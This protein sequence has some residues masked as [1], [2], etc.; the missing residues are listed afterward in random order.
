MSWKTTLV[1]IVLFVAAGVAIL[2]YS[3]QIERKAEGLRLPGVVEIQEVRLG[4]KVGG[5]VADVLV[6][7]G[8]MAK[9]N[10]LLVRFEAPELE[11]QR[12][13][14]QGRVASMQ[15][16]FEKAKN[17][18]RAE[19]IRQAR[20]DLET[21][22]ADLKLG[23]EDFE[24]AE[25]LIQQKTISRADYDIA[26][27]ALHRSR[28]RVASARAHLDLLL[29]GTRPEDIALAAANLAE[30]RGRL[31][32]IEANLAETRVVAP[33]RAVVEVVAVRKGDLV[34]ANTPVVRV[35]RADD[36]WV[37]VYVPETELGKIRLNQQASVTID[38]YPGRRFS[39]T[40]FKIASE[41]EFTPRNIQSV[42][43]RRFQVF[44]IKVR[45]EDPQGVFKAGMAA[46]VWFDF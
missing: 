20:S 41:S 29:A 7:E 13:Q 28:G 32:E 34:S 11:A 42:E 33:E 43:E 31:Q 26:R 45:V 10:Q 44:G 1:G 14:Q 2:L 23:M 25:R 46:D 6:R 17:G 3:S 40:V 36:L 5:R 19:D 35:L 15:A 16:E 38:A 9:T 30:A 27:A 37:K 8:D 18:P 21:A 24:R 12:A 22:E 4:S 39:G